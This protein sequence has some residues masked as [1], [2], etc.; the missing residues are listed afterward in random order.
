[1]LPLSFKEFLDFHGYTVTGKKSP[2]GTLKRRITDRDDDIYD[3]LL[4]LY[5]CLLKQEE[6]NDNFIINFNTHNTI[7]QSAQNMLS[8]GV[9]LSHG[10]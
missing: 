1:M 3:E 10:R 4:K 2:T 6:I 7:S 9:M 8:K 5:Y